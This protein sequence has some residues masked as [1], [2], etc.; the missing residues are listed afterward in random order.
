VHLDDTRMAT[1]VGLLES[2]TGSL[3]KAAG[4]Q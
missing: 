3:Q 1:M 2:T 4:S